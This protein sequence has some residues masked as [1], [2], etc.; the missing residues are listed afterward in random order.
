MN[1]REMRKRAI[2]KTVTWRIMATIITVVLVYFF[3][4]RIDISLEIGALEVVLKIAFYYLHE[5]GWNLI[6]WGYRQKDIS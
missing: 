5:R 3:T 6:A 2:V 1:M 4:R